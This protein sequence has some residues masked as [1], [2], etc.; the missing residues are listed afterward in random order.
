MMVDYVIE[1]QQIVHTFCYRFL[2]DEARAQTMVQEVF[3][4]AWPPVQ[5]NAAREETVR[6]LRIAYRDA[7]HALSKDSSMSR[8]V[9]I[10]SAGAVGDGAPVDIQM[11]LNALS[12]ECRSLVVLHYC[13]GLTLEEAAIIADLPIHEVRMCLLRARRLLAGMFAPLSPPPFD[14]VSEIDL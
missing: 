5:V 1:Y 6:L 13:C 8:P 4:Q 12:L 9:I 14:H 10:P 3:E 7:M 11:L 2:S